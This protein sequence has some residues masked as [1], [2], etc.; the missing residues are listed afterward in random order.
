MFSNEETQQ[1]E[2]LL[3]RHLETNV[4]GNGYSEDSFLVE[5][6]HHMDLLDPGLVLRHLESV[7]RE[8]EGAS[9][10]SRGR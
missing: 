1:V 4:P 6:V 2:T 3:A 5:P 10:T 7:I 8:V 9:G